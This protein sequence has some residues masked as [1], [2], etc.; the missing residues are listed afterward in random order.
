MRVVSNN[1]VASA[2]G[3]VRIQVDGDWV[4]ADNDMNATFVWKR[5]WPEFRVHVQALWLGVNKMRVEMPGV[6]YAS[7]KASRAFMGSVVMTP[8]GGCVTCTKFGTKEMGSGLF[9]TSD[10][11]M[12]LVRMDAAGNVVWKDRYAIHKGN[13]QITNGL[14]LLHTVTLIATEGLAW[15]INTETG[16]ILKK[17]RVTMGPSGEKSTARSVNGRL[18]TG[19]I[20]F[21][22]NPSGMARI[23]MDAKSIP[24]MSKPPFDLGPDTIRCDVLPPWGRPKGLWYS[25]ALEGGLRYNYLGPRMTKPKFTPQNPGYGGSADIDARHATSLFQIPGYKKGVGVA[26]KDDGQVYVQ[27][28]DKPSTRV[29]VGS[30]SFPCATIDGHVFYLNGGQM[31]EAAVAND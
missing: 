29:R 12:Y 2:P 11:G 25:I 19:Y 4:V 24:V 13:A 15:D 28:L 20:G 7:K 18:Y 26:L 10:W 6:V 17:Y 5:G 9:K 8:D 16:A 1:R 14:A 3:L 27:I 21:T 23:G 30:G 31:F 22:N